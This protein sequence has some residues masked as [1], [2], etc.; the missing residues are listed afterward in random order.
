LSNAIKFTPA[1][2]RIVVSAQRTGDCISVSVRDS[3]IGMAANDI[4]KAFEP[5][6]QVDSSHARKYGGTGLGLPL[7]KMFVELHGGGLAIESVLG[8][9]TIVT[10]SLPTAPLELHALKAAS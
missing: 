9:G 6:G 5:F 10:V 4:P 2:G 7:S 8:E 1:G 3:G